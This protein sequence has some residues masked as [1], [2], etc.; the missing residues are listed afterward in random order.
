MLRNYL[1]ID[2]ARDGHQMNL[3]LVESCR[4]RTAQL[5]A[6]QAAEKVK[7]VHA[8]HDR[9]ARGLACGRGVA[10]F[11]SAAQTRQQPKI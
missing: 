7:N 2:R 11:K 10:V 9:G 5:T 1:Y 3:L 4:M 8:R 6:A